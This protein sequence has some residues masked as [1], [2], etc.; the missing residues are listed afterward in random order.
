MT[1]SIAN[2]RPLISASVC[3]FSSSA[4]AA[5]DPH[6][7]LPPHTGTAVQ[8]AIDRGGAETRLKGDILDEKRAPSL[9]SLMVF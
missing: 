1:I 6:F 3:C 7:G 2:L 5:F 8:H 9:T 4:M